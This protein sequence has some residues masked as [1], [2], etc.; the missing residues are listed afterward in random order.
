MPIVNPAEPRLYSSNE[1]LDVQLS[2][3]KCLARLHVEQLQS[4]HNLLTFR[5]DAFELDQ[6]HNVFG[7][8]VHHNSLNFVP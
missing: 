2:F 4:G 6:H 1:R 8:V 7:G 3:E 5:R